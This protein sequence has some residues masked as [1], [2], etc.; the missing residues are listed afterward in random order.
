MA[1]CRIGTAKFFTLL[2]LLYRISV[3]AGGVNFKLLEQWSAQHK[4]LDPSHACPALLCA[5]QRSSATISTKEQREL[6]DRAAA[7]QEELDKSQA[8]TV[9]AEK[10]M[11]RSG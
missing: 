4:G 3:K 10:F 11:S 8:A 5:A 2:L 9:N 7:L 1:K 6:K